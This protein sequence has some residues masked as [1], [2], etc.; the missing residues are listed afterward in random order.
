MAATRPTTHT[1]QVGTWGNPVPR[2]VSYPLVALQRA[3]RH[4]CCPASIPALCRAAHAA[5]SALA[6]PG[7]LCGALQNAA[8][9]VVVDTGVILTEDTLQQPGCLLAIRLVG[10]GLHRIG[11]VAV[12][13]VRTGEELR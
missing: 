5:H 1:L 2:V 4:A 12:R 8:L 3:G 10:C 6:G 9:L 13:I 11:L 7:L